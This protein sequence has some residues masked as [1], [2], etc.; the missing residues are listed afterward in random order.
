[1]DSSSDGMVW[2]YWGVGS[3]VIVDARSEVVSMAVDLV[4]IGSM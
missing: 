2:G 4:D 3:E 1:M